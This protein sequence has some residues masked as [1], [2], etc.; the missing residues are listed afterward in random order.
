[1]EAKTVFDLN[2]MGCN[3]TNVNDIVEWFNTTFKYHVIYLKFQILNKYSGKTRP[4]RKI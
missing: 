3:K 1:M 4:F 2:Q